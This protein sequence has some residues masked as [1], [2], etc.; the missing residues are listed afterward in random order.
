M[1]KSVFTGMMELKSTR[2]NFTHTALV[3]DSSRGDLDNNGKPDIA[4]GSYDGYIY[5]W[6][7]EP[8]ADAS[9]WWSR[10]SAY[11]P[12]PGR[13]N[14][15]LSY[16]G[17]NQGTA[18]IDT[19]YLTAFTCLRTPLYPG[20]LRVVPWHT[21]ATAEHATRFRIIPLLFHHRSGRGSII[22]GLLPT[23]IVRYRRATR[24]TIP[25]RVIP[26]M[27]KQCSR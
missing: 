24:T 6:E 18:S 13:G 20:G 11:R 2:I 12:R 17:C 9:T 21:R 15:T 3:S 7:V 14:I 26:S 5:A 4:F 1:R 23:S 22:S 27:C 16:I 8:N 19:I 25:G 10:Q